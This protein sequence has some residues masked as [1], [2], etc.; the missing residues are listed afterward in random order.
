MPEHL[1]DRLAGRVAAD[2]LHGAAAAEA[3]S[4]EAIHRDPHRGEGVGRQGQED[5]ALD[6]EL[7]V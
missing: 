5:V 2:E 4:T 7:E 6:P 1:R 3:V